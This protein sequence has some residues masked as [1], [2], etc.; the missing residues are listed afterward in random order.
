MSNTRRDAADIGLVIPDLGNPFFPSLVQ[1][2]ERAARAR[3]V[4]V[5]IA[6]S[7]NDAAIEHDA[8]RMLIERRVG[9]ILVSATHATESVA[10]IT[11]A[12]KVV[13][14]IQLDRIVAEYCPGC[15]P[16]RRRRSPRS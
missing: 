15:V 8:F 4:G 7:D 2:V 9:A 6:N 3:G 1:A 13:P 16:I 12:A 11:D 14:V 5:L 10:T